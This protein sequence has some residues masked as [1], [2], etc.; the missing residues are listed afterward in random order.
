MHAKSIYIYFIL[1]TEQESY[2]VGLKGISY[3]GT[4]SHPKNLCTTN[5]Q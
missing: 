5:N 1:K 2:N 4:R 3:E